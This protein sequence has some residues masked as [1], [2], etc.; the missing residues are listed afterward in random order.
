[1][2]RFAVSVELANNEDQMRAQAGDIPAEKV[3]R[4]AV[5]GFVDSG[6]ARLVLPQSVV[7]QLGLAASQSVAVRYADGRR[8]HRPLA[9]DVR[10]TY[11]GRSSVFDAVV[12]PQ[13]DTALIGAIVLEGLDLVVDCT[14]QKLIPRDPHTIVAEIE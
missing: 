8:D 12:E 5:R 7:E 4:A 10:L 1:M 2:G 6:A 11:A 13:R 3:R 14:G 9:T